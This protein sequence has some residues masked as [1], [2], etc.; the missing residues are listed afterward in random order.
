MKNKLKYIFI[1]LVLLSNGYSFS[2]VVLNKGDL[3]VRFLKD[4]VDVI[5]G[6][7]FFNVLLIK[8]NSLEDRIFNLQINTPRNWEIVGD[9]SEK[10]SLPP[11]GNIKIPVRVTVDKNAKGGVG[12]AIVAVLNDMDGNLYD[13]E[14]AFLNIPINTEI[15]LITDK[16]SHYL[17]HK[18]LKSRFVITVENKGNVDETLNIKLNPDISLTVENENLFVT[19]VFIESGS[20]KN[21]TYEVQL[22]EDIDFEKF[23]NHKL[24]LTITGTDTIITKTIWFKYLDWKY[25]NSFPDD[26]VPLNIELSGYNIFSSLEAKYRGVIYGKILFKNDRDFFYSVENLNRTQE[27][28]NLYKNSRIRF[29]FTTPKTLIFLG[30]YTGNVEQSMFGRGIFVSKKIGSFASANAVFTQRVEHP[31]NNYGFFYN[32]QIKKR[33]LLEAGA[34]YTDD[35]FINTNAF[36]AYGKID[37]SLI[38]HVHISGLYGK[39]QTND[40]RINSRKY[41]GWGYKTNFSLNLDKLNIKIYSQ[42]GTPTYAGIFQGRN[43]TK[44]NAVFTLS[45]NKYINTTY[46]LLYFNPLYIVNEELFHDRYTSYQELRIIMNYRTLS[47]VQIYA[48]PNI[49][50]QSSNSFTAL[51]IE[52][53]LT[54]VGTRVEMGIRYFDNFNY[55]AASLNL[56]YG[57]NITTEYSN[58]FNGIYRELGNRLKPFPTTELTFSY[59]Q[60]YFGIHFVYHNGPYNINQQFSLLYYDF[61]TKTI[62]IIPTFERDF[63]KKKLNIVLHGSYVNDISSKSNRFGLMMGTEWYAGKGWT[64]RFINTTS[65]QRNLAGTGVNAVNTSYSA[66]YFEFGIKKAFHFDQP[67]L[68]FHNYEAVFFKD[69]N[70]NRIH[71]PNEPGVANVLTDIQRKDP[72]A[73]A[74]DP[75]YN[76]EFIT[77]ELYSNQEGIIQYT[78]LPEGDYIIKYSTQ[79]LNLGTFETEEARKDF[80]SDKDTVMQIPFMERNKLYGKVNLNR[81]KHSALGDIPLDNIKI[82]VE[83]D[84]K[85]YSTLTD[86]DGYF[87]LFIPVSDYYKVKINNIFFEH[88]NI[89]Q[90]YFI[91]KFNGYKQFEISFDF[92]E[93]ERTIQ[94]DESDFLVN[95]D[96]TA[97][98]DFSFEDIKVI[99]QTNL[100]GAIKD[101]NSL[102]PLH[103]NV[104]VYNG[105]N[106][107]ISET[108]SSNRSGIYFTSFFAGENYSIRVFSKGYWVHKEFLN[109]QQVTTFEN[110]TT[111]VML[112]KINID[113][114]INTD[115]LRFSTENS[116]LSPLAKAELDN[117]ITLLFLNPQVQI[118]VSGHADNIE[119]LIIDPKRISE[120]RAKAVAAYLTAGGVPNN[121]IKIVALGSTRPVTKEDTED[122]RARNRRVE[123]RVAAY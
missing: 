86:K 76:G 47:N 96:E 50:Q 84:E 43:D 85:T 9:A 78:N 114:E 46:S 23:K 106:E 14:Y 8:N 56:K 17:D 91:V 51:P 75:N 44:A 35:K 79:G 70:G 69:L 94:F 61:Q 65:F 16:G 66:T 54:V 108:A 103:A 22:K 122:G 28:N 40:G 102:L 63:F 13:S 4:K 26:N 67:R 107:L 117:I 24:Y 11:L 112:K 18:Y 74:A 71:D 57:Y 105:K 68:K 10:I 33:I 38:K 15:S 19:D 21:L 6:K 34:D 90:D 48:G 60:K 101:A 2:Q 1:F 121:R 37:L 111:D 58:Y 52:S 30:D 59:K 36:S 93:K 119:A 73:D 98:G 89:R 110:L 87:E 39:S 99:K 27:S 20:S 25:Y 104:S 109:I 113:D 12:Y 64:F 100:K 88:F 83:G 55:R 45:N 92:D 118:E 62:N 116:E 115:N 120:S 123:I 7:S 5:P 29:E 53:P 49:L 41:N 95:G 82:T 3:D 31:K 81:T 80:K 77:N 97:D 32:H 42:Y 72:L